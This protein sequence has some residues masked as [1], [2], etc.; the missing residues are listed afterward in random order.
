MANNNSTNKIEDTANDMLEVLRSSMDQGLSTTEQKI[1]ENPLAAVGIAAG[2]GFI[3][4]F[5]V[6]RSLIGA[7]VTVALFLI[8][9]AILVVAVMRLVDMLKEV[10]PEEEASKSTSTG[11]RVA[12]NRKSSPKLEMVDSPVEAEPANT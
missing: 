6:I 12:S 8:K 9:P 2:A 3:F 4:R 5:R 1:R 10:S 11:K 7:A